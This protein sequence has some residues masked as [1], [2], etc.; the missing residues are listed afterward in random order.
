MEAKELR[1]MSSADLARKLSELREEIGH[2][3]LKRATSRLENPMKLRQT[4]RDLARVET[5]LK[6]KAVQGGKV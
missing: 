6:E 3:K 2:L 1:D 5:I 4:K